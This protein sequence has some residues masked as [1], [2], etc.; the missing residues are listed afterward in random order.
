MGAVELGFLLHNMSSEMIMSDKPNIRDA[1]ADD[2][3]AIT[4]IYAVH[5]REGF[6]S[7]ELDPPSEHDMAE[8]LVTIQAGGLP[9]LVAELE[10][11]VAGYACAS[12]FRP[13]PAYCHTVENSVY[14]APWAQ[15]RGVGRALLEALI[16]R[17][18]GLGRRQ[19]IAVIGDRNN[20]ASIALHKAVGFE[21]S[22]LLQHVGFKQGRWV[23]IV[24]M[25]TTVPASS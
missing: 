5:V 21:P 11:R 3:S 22:G 12:L 15:R 14:M 20:E 2:I 19:M 4:S 9:Y 7:F 23:D 18:E 24:I 6:G 13:R 10:G 25:Q 8:R 1:V 17:C 16:S